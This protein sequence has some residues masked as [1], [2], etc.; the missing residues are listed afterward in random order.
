MPGPTFSGFDEPRFKPVPP[1]PVHHV[2]VA[3]VP[4]IPFAVISV[5]EDEQIGLAE[6]VADVIL[7]SVFTVT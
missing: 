7:T 2:K 3:P 4:T 6:A 5:V 1:V